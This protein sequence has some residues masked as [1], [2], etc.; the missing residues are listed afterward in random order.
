MF[1]RV[2]RFYELT[3]II[4]RVERSVR[5]TLTFQAAIIKRKERERE[6]ERKKSDG[7]KRKTIFQLAIKRLM[8]NFESEKT[9]RG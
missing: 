4:L 3:Q 1:G 9:I 2:P 5:S 7:I 8:N 6:R